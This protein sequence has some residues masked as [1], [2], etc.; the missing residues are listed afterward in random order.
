M[1]CIV[2]ESCLLPSDEP[3]CS[4]ALHH[5]V[6]LRFAAAVRFRAGAWTSSVTQQTDRPQEDKGRARTRTLS[7]TVRVAAEE[8]IEQKPQKPSHICTTS[9]TAPVNASVQANDQPRA[10]PAEGGHRY[11]RH[12]KTHK[13]PRVRRAVQK[14]PPYHNQQIKHSTERT[15]PQMSSTDKMQQRIHHPSTS[16]D[17][18]RHQKNDP[19]VHNG[20]P[21]P[22]HSYAHVHAPVNCNQCPQKTNAHLKHRNRHKSHPCRT[23]IKPKHQKTQHPVHRKC[24]LQLGNI[25]PAPSFTIPRRP[26]GLRTNATAAATLHRRTCHPLHHSK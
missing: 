20:S 13:S 26:T 19:V 1:V 5:P 10:L 12:K 11:A 9:V 6:A 8:A 16:Y 7:A 25:P 22:C 24:P 18:T 4:A 23:H 17:S 15:L 14:A 2:D 21:K 3:S